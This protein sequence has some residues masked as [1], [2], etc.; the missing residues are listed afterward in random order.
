MC[1]QAVA[2]REKEPKSRFNVAN[3]DIASNPPYLG[4]QDGSF[5][6]A[7]PANEM[8]LSFQADTS[9]PSSR[10]PPVSRWA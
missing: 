10:T 2:W 9:I 7:S 1:S 8:P 3:L 4:Q 5:T 6:K